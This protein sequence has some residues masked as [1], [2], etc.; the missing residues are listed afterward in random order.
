MAGGHAVHPGGPERRARGLRAVSA[1]P[2]R[3]RP[4]LPP[5]PLAAR[6]PPTGLQAGP[7]PGSGLLGSQPDPQP[8]GGDPVHLALLAD[9]LG[10]LLLARFPPF[11]PPLVDPSAPSRAARQLP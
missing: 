9:R 7:L 6:S 10:R 3:L 2:A 11:H 4:S 1:P 5:H 8:P